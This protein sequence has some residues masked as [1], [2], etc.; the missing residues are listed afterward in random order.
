[1]SDSTDTNNQ[2][3]QHTAHP[4]YQHAVQQVK[5]HKLIAMITGSITIAI[6]LVFVAMALYNS[7]GASQLDLSRP[8]YESVRTKAQQDTTTV[9]FAATGVLDEAAIN[10]FSDKYDNQLNSMRR[11]NVFASDSLSTKSLQIDQDTAASSAK[12]SA[13]Q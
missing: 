9:S 1:M 4:H 7:S 5:D 13:Q 3:N 8:G 2:E 11:Q 12:T 10:E 6:F